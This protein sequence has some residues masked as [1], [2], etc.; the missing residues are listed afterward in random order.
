MGCKILKLLHP[1]SYKLYYNVFHF[2]RG[3]KN[4]RHASTYQP[5]PRYL[6]HSPDSYYEM[7]PQPTTA[8]KQP[9]HH[10]HSKSMYSTSDDSDSDFATPMASPNRS[11]MLASKRQQLSCQDLR[12]SYNHNQLTSRQDL[13]GSTSQLSERRSQSA[14]R[15]DYT[16]QLNTGLQ[17]RRIPPRKSL[18]PIPTPRKSSKNRVPKYSNPG[19]P[20]YKSP[21]KIPIPVKGANQQA[22]RS[23]QLLNLST[24]IEDLRRD[25][26]PIPSSN[27]NNSDE[28]TC[29]EDSDTD[30]YAEIDIKPKR[31]KVDKR[32]KTAEIKSI[33]KQRSKE[34]VQEENLYE[35]LVPVKSSKSKSDY[36][37]YDE[38]TPRVKRKNQKNSRGEKELRKRNGRQSVASER[39]GE[40]RNRNG[41]KE[42]KRKVEKR[43]ENRKDGRERRNEKERRGINRKTSSD[44][45][46]SS[47]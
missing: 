5:S 47:R 39:E 23:V 14:Q 28:S 17:Q 1:F 27:N 4:T 38:I 41:Q 20:H 24:R 22:L 36:N 8:T 11:P 18:D 46:D 21:S 3:N 6:D 32:I 37:P 7:I 29:V 31:D 40:A 33:R 43:E 10:R 9:S 34:S 45:S 13:R 35:D 44:K 25:R 30:T 26:L 15:P 42:E 16:N 2:F 12:S 19:E